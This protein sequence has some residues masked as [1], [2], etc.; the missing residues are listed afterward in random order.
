M[1]NLRKFTMAWTV[2]IIYLGKLTVRHEKFKKINSTISQNSKVRNLQ[3]GMAILGN[4][5]GMAK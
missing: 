5:H 3:C 4:S 1:A 2:H